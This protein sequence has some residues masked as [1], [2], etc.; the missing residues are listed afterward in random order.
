MIQRFSDLFPLW[1]LLFSGLA[2]WFPGFFA[3]GAPTIIPLLGVV[4]FCMGVTLGPEDFRRVAKMPGVVAL[5]LALQYGAMPFFGWLIAR[6]M[7]FPPEVAAGI[8]IVGACPGGTASNV[9]TY[10]A[11]GHLALSIT[12]TLCSTLLAAALT[13]TLIWVYAGAWIDVPVAAMT[14]SVFKIVLIPVALGV[15]VNTIWKNRVTRAL[16]VFP[17]VSV[18]AIVVIIAIILGL[19]AESIGKS[20]G[21]VAVAVIIH[22]VLGLAAGYWLSWALGS[23][24]ALAADTATRRTL[25]IEVGMQNSGLGVALALKYFGAAAALPGAIFSIWH[26]LSGAFLASYWS[27]NG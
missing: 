2:L 3:A 27:R 21:A 22:N 24:W 8:I 13:P 18:A 12:L 14:W 9:V 1:A 23:F 19:N 25:A 11:K 6:V 15:A 10:L 5:G 7:D 20:G 4:M 17:A 26:N 16:H